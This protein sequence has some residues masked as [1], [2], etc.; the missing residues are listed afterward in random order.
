MRLEVVMAPELSKAEL[1]WLLDR[2]IEPR[3]DDVWRLLK[4]LAELREFV[5]ASGGETS[6]S[7]QDRV[8]ERFGIW[9]FGN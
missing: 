4:N 2:T 1:G 3:P 8:S 9:C 7:F 5:A 6:R